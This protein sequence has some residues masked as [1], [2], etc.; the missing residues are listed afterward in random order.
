RRAR[1]LLDHRQELGV[2]LRALGRQRPLGAQALLHLALEEAALHAAVDDVPRQHRVA[3][4]VA[5]DVGVAVDAGL[6]DR[7]A[8]V[9]AVALGGGNRRR[10]APVAERQ[11][12]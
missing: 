2:L 11:Q 1:T 8:P 6:G 9:L 10:D 7:R 3:R 12:R 4:A 5:E